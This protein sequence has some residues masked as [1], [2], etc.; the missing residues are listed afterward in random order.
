MTNRTDPLPTRN[1][2]CQQISLIASG[3][4]NVVGGMGGIPTIALDYSPNWDAQLF[5]WA[6]VQFIKAS[7]AKCAKG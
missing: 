7:E 1:S 3:P 5:E 6:R 4:N 2:G